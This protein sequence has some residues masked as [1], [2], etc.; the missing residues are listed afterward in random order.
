MCLGPVKEGATQ[1]GSLE[2]YLG[3]GLGELTKITKR[4]T[5]YP[6]RNNRFT[7]PNSMQVRSSLSG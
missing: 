7:F 5:L 3:E 4:V 2:I 6:Q 1:Q